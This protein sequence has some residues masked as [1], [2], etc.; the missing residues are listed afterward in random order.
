MKN[1]G[2][3]DGI[4]QDQS[5]MYVMNN[6]S[7]LGYGSVI[8]MNLLPSLEG[9][10]T[11]ESATENLKCVQEEVTKVKTVAYDNGYFPR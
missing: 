9:K 3:A 7:K 1:A 5:T 8:I 4:V 10:N 2:L 6:L 11:N